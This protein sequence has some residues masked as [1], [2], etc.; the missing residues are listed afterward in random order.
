M[1]ISYRWLSDYI[2]HPYSPEEL[3]A[4]L[5]ALGIEVEAIDDKARR[6]H[7]IVA[8]EVLEVSDHPNADK[9]HLTKVTTGGADILHIVCGAPNVRAGMKV[10]VALVAADLGEGFIIK[11]SKI[12]GEASEG[13]LCS[14]KELGL[15]DEHSG[16]LELPAD[17]TLGTPF[18]EI[19]GA[20]D[21][22]LEI[23][24]TPN[25]ADCLSHIGIAREVAIASGAKVNIPQANKKYLDT[26]KEKASA[27]AK[28]TIEAP[29]LCPRYAARIL[30][31]VTVKE[32]P[33]WLKKKLEAVGL[34]PRNNIVDITNFVLM[35][36]GHPLHAFDLAKV[37]DKHVIVR[38]AR[39]FVK[40]FTTLDDKER[41]LNPD[42]LL[43]SDPSQGLAIA[44]I[45]GGESSEIT[46]STRDVL[47]ESAYFN[48]SSIRRSA[49]LLGLSTDA[50]YRFERGVDMEN[51]IYAVDR[52][53]ALMAELGGADVLAGIIDEYPK[54][55]DKKV[56]SF[57]PSR[58]N[59]L[60]ATNISAKK[61]EA[62]LDSAGFSIL[63]S[64]SD[65]WELTAPSWRVDCDQ[66][67]DA[68][69]EIARITGYDNLPTSTEDRIPMKRERDL[70]PKRGFNS[71]IRSELTAL[72]FYECLS[73]PMY[74]AKLAS[75]FHESPVELMNPLTS[76]L[77]CMRTS[78]I[79]NLL[80]VAR[81]NERFGASG[82]RLFE[83]GAVF[84]YGNTAQTVAHIAERWEISLLLKDHLE[85]KLAYNSKE[86]RA[87]IF[88]LRSAIEQLL[89]HLGLSKITVT[90]LSQV[91]KLG[92]WPLAL[93]YF[94]ASEALGISVGREL[95]GVAG[96]TSAELV[97]QFDL[98]SAP[99][100]ATLSFDAVFALARAARSKERTIK[101]LPKYP[102]VERDIALVVGRDVS[103]HALLEEVRTNIP[104]ELLED[105]RIFDMFESKEMKA[106][107]K[108]SLG[109]RVSLRSHERTLEDGE[110]D[111]IVERIT[112]SLGERIGATLRS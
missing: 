58:A 84:H 37:K 96:K 60:L 48:P 91:K 20:D 68:I 23:G 77:E 1:N 25:R 76:E 2:T 36:C 111:R 100:A 38:T 95:V 31:N 66:E 61:M 110:V 86:L 103:A 33:D 55:I 13:M 28:V 11:K 107:A 22:I 39:D 82:Q 56:F 14:A 5:T 104:A 24:I 4:K 65:S 47:I 88:A 83:L 92:D 74:Q 45:M 93:H 67:V 64:S 62:A 51:V 87:D 18:A 52:A 98:R 81:R 73:T 50:S 72:G 3:A 16:L 12:R 79:G 108:K 44:G 26:S 97:R 85:E 43:I 53:A 29:E 101:S 27:A 34:R 80:D 49:K 112:R 63:P 90:P 59:M 21:V 70:L 7:N 99:Y 105:M 9:L 106:D 94:D 42:T 30:R 17:T 10:V 89:S 6:Y 57:R 46:D 109:V 69:E 8:G 71:L 41:T 19:I 75:Q 40:K 15:S 32:S 35:E 54:K 78:I 102:S